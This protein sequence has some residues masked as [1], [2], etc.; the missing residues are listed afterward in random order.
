MR[1]ELP[2]TA[3]EAKETHKGYLNTKLDMT[4]KVLTVKLKAFRSKYQEAVDSGRSGHGLVVLLYY[5]L[6]ERIWCEPPAPQQLEVGMETCGLNRESTTST[7]SVI[8]SESG[9]G[10]ESSAHE[11]GNADSIENSSSSTQATVRH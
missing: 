9:V 7:P 8:N 11:D 2:A 6:C 1:A 4:K 10:D 3:D 5:E